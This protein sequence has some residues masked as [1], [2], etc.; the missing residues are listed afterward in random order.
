[1][2][3]KK[4]IDVENKLMANVFARKK[5]VLV[6]GKG[7]LV[8]DIQGKEYLDFTSSYGVAALGHSHPKVVKAIS[9]QAKKIISCHSGFYNPKR[10]ELLQKIVNLTPKE[11]NKVF[12]SNSGAES[13]ECAIKLAR[14]YTRK[15]EIISFMG[16]YHGKTLGAL[17][18]T[19]DKKYRKPFEPLIP[20]IKH[21]PPNNLDKLQAAITSKTAAVLIEPI[22]GEGGVRVSSQGFLQGAKDICDNKKVLLILD[23]V[24]TSFGRTGK[25]FSFEHWKIIPDILCLAKPFAGG[26]PIGIT[27]AKE[28]IMSSLKI[29]EH[30]STFSGSP[31]VCAAACAA[32][33]VLLEEKLA[34]K[35]FNQGHYF[36]SKLEDLKNKYRTVKEVRGLGLMLAIELRKDVYEIIKKAE[37]KGLLILNAGRNVIRFLPPLIVTNNQIDRA[38]AIIDSILGAEIN[39]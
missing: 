21:I 37:D 1:L 18:T 27:I 6:K 31:V 8:W 14:K 13:I 20:E 9:K 19:W 17:S 39:G 36:K 4:I 10:A 38:I 32:I 2:N 22:R 3:E 30:T 29:G 12:L 24:Q 16:A 11:L 25:I 34:D 7:A 23:E 15:T 28:N 33:D 5:I 26:L 35:A